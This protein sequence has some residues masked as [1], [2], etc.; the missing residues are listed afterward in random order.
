MSKYGSLIRQVTVKMEDLKGFGESKHQAKEEAKAAG[1]NPNKLYKIYSRNTYENYLDKV[2]KFAAW[3]KEHYDVKKLS[4]IEKD[5]VICFLKEKINK[6]YS[7][8]TIQIYKSAINKVIN[9]NVTR[10]D[11]GLEKRIR[12]SIVRSRLS[13]EN[14]KH[15]N[16]NNYDDLINFCRAVGCRRE[17]VESVTPQDLRIRLNGVYVVLTE[18]GGKRREAKVVE[19]YEQR[20]IQIFR[21]RKEKEKLFGKVT[22]KI[23]IHSLRAEYCRTRY[24]EELKKRGF[25]EVTFLRGSPNSVYGLSKSQYGSEKNYC[26]ENGK[27]VDSN[28]HCKDGRILNRQCMQVITKDMGHNRISVMA[29]NYLY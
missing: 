21:E 5:H 1:E 6:G 8:W 18:K 26:T 14:D 3:E 7:A 17:G 29:T 25:G 19:N 22:N 9:M 27:M 15:F 28:Y 16:P 24:N 23:D 13:T 10:G 11:I 4:Q 2:A 12:A 20:V